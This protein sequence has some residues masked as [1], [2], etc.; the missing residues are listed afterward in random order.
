LRAF[1]A[2]VRGFLSKQPRDDGF[3]DE[4]QEHLQ[5]LADRFVAQG[6]SR[7]KPPWPRGGSSAIPVD[8]MRA[9]RQE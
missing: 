2:R 5:L 3:D 7:K 9:L 1:A 6:M 4:I 8:P